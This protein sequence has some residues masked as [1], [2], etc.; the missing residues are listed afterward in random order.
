LENILAGIEMRYSGTGFAARFNQRSIMKAMDL[1]DTASGT[2]LVKRPGK[3]RWTYEEPEEQIIVTD[4]V[5]LWIYKPA[6]NQV[7]VGQAPTFFADGKGASFLSDMKLV[8]EKFTIRLDASVPDSHYVLNL[9]PHGTA[10]DIAAIYLTVAAR[11]YDITRIVTYNAYGDEN[12]IDLE[13]IEFKDTI[14]DDLFRFAIPEGADVLRLD[15]SI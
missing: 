6:D 14:E 3:M 7:A 15:E 2:M 5:D 8:R 13:Q 1:A 12:R 11:T 4:G 10:I 9:T